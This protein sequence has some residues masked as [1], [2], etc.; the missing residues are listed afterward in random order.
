MYDDSAA[1]H[2]DHHVKIRVLYV[3]VVRWQHQNDTLHQQVAA[4]FTKEQRGLKTHKF[5]LNLTIQPVAES[6]HT[7]THSLYTRNNGIRWNICLWSYVYFGVCA[8]VLFLFFT[9]FLLLLH[10]IVHFSDFLKW[11]FASIS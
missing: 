3:F 6:S 7:H 11:F 5:Y 10:R 4:K 1:E 8:C 2:I 9:L